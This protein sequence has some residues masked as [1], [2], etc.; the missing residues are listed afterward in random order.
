MSTTIDTSTVHHAGA[1]ELDPLAYATGGYDA[2]K[3]DGQRKF[4]GGRI[5]P[6]YQLLGQQQRERLTANTYDLYRNCVLLAWALRRHMNDIC[7][8]EWRPNTGDRSLDAD[9]KELMDRDSRPYVCD[10][11]GRRRD[12][13]RWKLGCRLGTANRTTH[14]CVHE[15]DHDGKKS[16]RILRRKM[17]A[18]RFRCLP[19]PPTFHVGKRSTH[20]WRPEATASRLS[21]QIPALPSHREIQRIR[22]C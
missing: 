16:E 7:C 9:L 2:L 17:L 21:T 3:A 1:V 5:V 4:V 20:R 19:P 12:N 22:P 6:E 13:A 8:W 18:E 15:S 14:F 11:G 10:A